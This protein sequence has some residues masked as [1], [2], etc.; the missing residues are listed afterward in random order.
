MQ[1][2]VSSETRE[3][4]RDDF[5]MHE[6]GEFEIKGFGTCTLYSLDDEVKDHKFGT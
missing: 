5:V 4:I 6:R 3:L 1:I 2:T